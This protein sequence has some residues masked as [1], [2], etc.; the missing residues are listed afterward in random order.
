MARA[1]SSSD[2]HYVGG[3]VSGKKANLGSARESAIAIKEE[4]AAQRHRHLLQVFTQLPKPH[5]TSVFNNLYLSL[6]L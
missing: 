6:Q 2:D 1:E 5:W 4:S 3:T